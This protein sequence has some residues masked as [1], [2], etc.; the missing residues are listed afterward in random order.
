[1]VSW[2]LKK[3]LANSKRLLVVAKEDLDR[4]PGVPADLEAFRQRANLLHLLVGQLP[5]IE[6]K[7]TL[8]TRC[9]D[10]LGNNTGSALKT[11]HQQ[12]LLDRLALALGKLLELL[13]LVERRVGGTKA[14][15][16]GAVDALFLAVV[17]QLGSASIVSFWHHGTS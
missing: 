1:M 12:D 10:R 14:R 3:S 16:G 2:Y 13:V 11:P 9:C 15:V 7:V 5:S 6:L 8:D 4:Q 17:E